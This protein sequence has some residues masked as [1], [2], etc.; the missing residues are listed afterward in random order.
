MGDVVIANIPKMQTA[1]FVTSDPRNFL[2]VGSISQAMLS[3][4]LVDRPIIVEY[5]KTV[6]PTR[7]VGSD[8]IHEEEIPKK[9]EKISNGKGKSI[10]SKKSIKQNKQRLTQLVIE[11]ESSEHTESLDRNENE[12]ALNN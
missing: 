9:K 8:S 12:S 4:V 6:V 10:V 3:R 1:T 7:E 11:E 2:I 5:L